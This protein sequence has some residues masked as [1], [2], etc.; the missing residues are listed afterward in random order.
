MTV[1]IILRATWRTVHTVRSTC[2]AT[3]S[4]CEASPDAADGKQNC[5]S[6]SSFFFLF[7]PT[8]RKPPKRRKKFGAREKRQA[9]VDYPCQ[10]FSGRK[11]LSASNTGTETA[12]AKESAEVEFSKV[13]FSKVK[14]SS[15]EVESAEASTVNASFFEASAANRSAAK[16]SPIHADAVV[17]SRLL[18]EESTSSPLKPVALLHAPVPDGSIILAANGSV[19]VKPPT[20]NLQANFLSEFSSLE[21][22]DSSGGKV[23]V[24]FSPEQYAAFCSFLK[25]PQNSAAATTNATTNTTTNEIAACH[26]RVSS[27]ANNLEP[28]TFNRQK[29]AFSKV[30]SFDLKFDAFNT[31]KEN[32]R[33]IPR[34]TPSAVRRFATV[35]TGKITTAILSLALHRA[36][37]HPSIRK[38]A[39]AAGFQNENLKELR[40]HTQ[41]IKDFI[42][43]ASKTQKKEGRP[44]TDQS[45]VLDTV[46]AA[47]SADVIVGGDGKI[48]QEANAPSMRSTGRLYGLQRD[49]VKRGI[50]NRKNL[51]VAKASNGN[52]RWWNILRRR[53]KGTRTI[54]SFIRD[55][56]V[57]WVVHHENVI[58]S[59]I[60]S[61][62]LFVKLP[63][64]TQKH[65][66]TK[67]LLEIPVRELHNR[68]LSELPVA[69]D[70]PHRWV[71]QTISVWYSQ[72]NKLPNT[73]NKSIAMRKGAKRLWEIHHQEILSEIARTEVLDHLE[74]TDDLEVASDDEENQGISSDSDDDF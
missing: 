44:N 22:S 55:A 26:L 13:E 60:V 59:P 11:G 67:L 46:A 39:K 62:T 23:A 40:Y 38:I 32:G 52:A 20:V 12:P 65:R 70:R 15:A 25:H 63:G 10:N 56:V 66:V 45:E 19:A 29:V 5:C 21:K 43:L 41:Q 17:D 73:C 14:E 3:R 31:K 42:A 68:M 50:T 54:P 28:L 4:L 2:M 30:E 69:R 37:I 36:L 16:A 53:H 61:E 6:H 72:T 7:M 71:L 35:A 51:R 64:S 9:S 47:L 48:M 34:D 1:L 49:Q 8:N 58:P 24:I 33:T 57:D 18:P 74:D 27:V